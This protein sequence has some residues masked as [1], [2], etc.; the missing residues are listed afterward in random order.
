MGPRRGSLKGDSKAPMVRSLSQRFQ[1]PAD[2]LVP[3]TDLSGA[4]RSW[5]SPRQ[6]SPRKEP[7][8]PRRRGGT[9]RPASRDYLLQTTP[10]MLNPALK[11][12]KVVALIRAPGCPLEV[13]RR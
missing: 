6:V 4:H 5:V 7:T 13:Y 9:R 11:W 3:D 8:S 2:L 10:L 12:K 1:R